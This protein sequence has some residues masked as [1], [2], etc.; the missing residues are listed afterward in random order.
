[1]WWLRTPGEASN[2]AAFVGSSGSIS[3]NGGVVDRTR[4]AVANWPLY[5]RVAVRPVD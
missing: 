5:G 3:E 4:R 1:M 2:C